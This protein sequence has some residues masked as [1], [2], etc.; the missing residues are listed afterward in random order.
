MDSSGRAPGSPSTSPSSDSTSSGSTNRPTRCAGSLDRAAQFVAR[1]RADEHVVGAEQLRQLGIGGAAAVE[2]RA[3]SEQD[4][5]PVAGGADERVRELGALGLVLA[6]R[7]QLLELVDCQHAVPFARETAGRAAQLA[8]GLLAGTDH[9]LRPILAARQH[10]AGER[11]QQP[12]SHDRRLPAPRRADDREQ[13]SADEAR[14]QLGDEPFAPEEVLGVVGLERGETLVWADH[15]RPVVVGVAGDEARALAR[16]LQLRDAAGQLGLDCARL[17]ATGGRAIRDRVD[18]ARRLPPR[19][20]ARRLVDAARN[21]LAARQQRLDR[22]RAALVGRRIDP[23]DRPDAVGVEWL[24]HDRVAR[25]Q[26]RQRRRLRPGG[27]H[28]GRDPV[29]RGHEPAQRGTHLGRRAIGVVDHDQ[30]GPPDPAGAREDGQR[31]LGR[32]CPGGV[33]HGGAFA[34]GVARELGREP[35]LAHAIGADERDQ[36]ARPV[37]RALPACPQPAQLVRAADQW[38]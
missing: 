31:G 20:L 35:G 9:G 14:H 13:R 34:V 28:Q 7:E 19:P 27:Q 33:E 23:G 3:H 12:G 6:C 2:V 16:R 21:P 24:E 5:G 4:D 15:R 30:R 8:Q 18:A 11:G 29:E 26:P 22:N 1:Q 17:V 32:A 10:A 25:F 38:R 37:R 36:R